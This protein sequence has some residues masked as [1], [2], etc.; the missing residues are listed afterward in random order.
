MINL[1][2]TDKR[3]LTE[4]ETAFY[5][6]MSRSYLRQAR[7]S[8]NRDNHTPAP[9]FIKIGR[10]VR[11]LREDLDAWLCSFQRLEHLGQLGGVTHV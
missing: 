5:I 10:A 4:Q 3:V 1:S 9:P 7:M 6:G 11:Y 8:G 2:E